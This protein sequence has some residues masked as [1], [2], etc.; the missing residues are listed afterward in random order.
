MID[1]G[2]VI[3]KAIRRIADE[4]GFDVETVE[5]AIKD[6]REPLD[7][8]AMVD[9]GIFCFRGP[10]QNVK[11]DN[12]SICLSGKI[13]ASTNVAKSLLPVICDRISRWDHEDIGQLLLLLNKMTAIM[14]LNP[15][16]YADL[17]CLSIDPAQLPTE[18]IPADLEG[19]WA[20]DRHG[21]C[22][23]GI[24]ANRIV[25]EADLRKRNNM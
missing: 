2:I 18:P 11:Y 21:R 8:N 15:D 6:S 4:Y 23:V 20:M 17:R 14:E 5:K 19:V 22:L 25:D 12:A 24:D 13:L 16:A 1:S 7:L 10:N 9:E 3:E